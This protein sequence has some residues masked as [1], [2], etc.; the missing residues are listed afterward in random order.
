MVVVV[1][2]VGVVQAAAV[3]VVLPSS[4]PLCYHYTYKQAVCMPL[5]TTCSSVL[6]TVAPP[7]GFPDV[8]IRVPQLRKHV[9]L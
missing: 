9:V 1:V 6:C 7:D 5:V 3:V 2:V 8:H 4:G